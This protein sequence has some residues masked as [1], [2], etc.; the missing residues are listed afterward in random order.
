MFFFIYSS[1]FLRENALLNSQNT[2]TQIA[3]TSFD[4]NSNFNES[5]INEIVNNE[6]LLIKY[7]KQKYNK[8]VY[9]KSTSNNYI[10]SIVNNN[11]PINPKS[12]IGQMYWEKNTHE[13]GTIWPHLQK[14]PRICAIDRLNNSNSPA[15]LF[16]VDSFK[17][18]TL[19]AKKY[20]SEFDFLAHH[21][22]EYSEGMFRARHPPCHIINNKIIPVN[23]ILFFFKNFFIKLLKCRLMAKVFSSLLFIFFSPF[24]LF[25]YIIIFFFL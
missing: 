6:E 23:F 5:I 1:E 7:S 24:F 20:P 13:P 22:L 17:A 15:R 4:Y 3:S 18:L 21:V 14:V 9:G 8:T 12:I 25:F 2:E 11:E 19:L 16:L 10:W